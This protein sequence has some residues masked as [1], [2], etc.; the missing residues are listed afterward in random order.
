MCVKNM[1]NM[2]SD[3]QI[4]KI[5]KYANFYWELQPQTTIKFVA[6]FYRKKFIPLL[7]HSS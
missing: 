4:F 1:K 3:D 2:Q 5:R 6:K 7:K